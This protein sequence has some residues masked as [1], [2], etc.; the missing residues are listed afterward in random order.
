MSEKKF[1]F[2]SPGVF[3][4]EIDNSQLPR[5]PG[6]IGPMI[7]GRTRK[8]PGMRPVTVESYS[9]FVTVFG[10]PVAGAQGE[11]V[12]RDGNLTAPTYAA[13]AAQAWLK[14]NPTVTMVRL[15]GEQHPDAADGTDGAAGWK[16]G[17]LSADDN[18]GG[19][20]GL[21]LFPSGS[22]AIDANNG[23][24]TGSLVAVIYN[25]TGV[26]GNR[27]RVSGYNTAA[28]TDV[29]V[30]AS[31][32]L[33]ESA[34][35]G[36]V[37]LVMGDDSI[38]EFNFDRN[39]DKFIR[40]V[41]NTNPTLLNSDIN[42]T[43]ENYFLGESF[44]HVVGGDFNQMY[45]QLGGEQVEPN[46]STEKYLAALMPLQS[47]GGGQ[48]EQSNRLYASQKAS[49][50]WF[51]SQ[52][53]SGN[54]A[55]YKPE[56]MQKLFRIEA[57][58]G[59]SQTQ[60]EVKISVVDI[61][62]S[63]NTSD[64]Y[65]TFTILLRRLG[66][67]DARPETLER[68]SGCNLNPSSPN[69][70]AAK[71]GDRYSKYDSSEKRMKA[72]GNHSNKSNIVRVVMD[73][74]VDAGSADAAYLPFGFWGAP[75]YRNVNLVAAATDFVS[76][77]ETML[78]GSG[79]GAFGTKGSSAALDARILDGVL[80]HAPEFRFPEVPLVTDSSWVGAAPKKSYFG[81]YLGKSHT[82]ASLNPSVIDM[83]CGLAQG[84]NDPTVAYGIEE[85]G[86]T[87]D[88]NLTTSTVVTPYVFTLDDVKPVTDKPTSAE[89]VRGARLAGDSFTAGKDFPTAK[90]R[91]GASV[92]PLT[93]DE[94]WKNVLNA[95]F[96]KFTTCLHGGTDGLDI[97]ER[98]PFRNS[99]LGT[100]TTD[101][102]KHTLVRAIDVVRDPEAA[103]YNLLVAPGVTDTATTQK[104][105]DV[106]EN[107]G[108]AMAIIDLSS[109]SLIPAA[110]A[111]TS[112]EVRSANSIE[113]TVDA[114]RD[115]GLNTSY[116]ACYYPWIKI[117][118]TFTSQ[119]LW[120][121]PSI[122]ALGAYSHT[123]RV[124]APWFA[125]AGFS[126]GGLSEGAAGIPV[127]DTSRRLTS[128][129]RDALYE[130]NIN[131]IAQ[132]PAEGIVIFGQKTLQITPSALDRVNVRRL[133]IYLKK[134]IS[135]IASRMLFDQNTQSTWNRFIGQAEPILRSVKSRYGLEDF[136]LILDEST[137][138]PDLQDR[139]I[140][141]AKILLK[142]T[143]S[144]EF[145]AIDFAITNTGASFE[146]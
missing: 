31:C 113:T 120:A 47:T 1:K 116:G 46:V 103:Q 5:E 102:A 90:V 97:L 139:N 68:F 52:D 10:E 131:P 118:D 111:K 100:E 74:D 129:D 56:D 115:R 28:G 23:Q 85:A 44:E 11:D 34:T 73:S 70:I 19:A 71:I 43:V 14:N 99:A 67:T 48:E 142:P 61:K 86:A 32:T 50:G 81:T 136:K 25:K 45:S 104:M 3:V 130:A 124:K 39:S 92:N 117:Q 94:S 137:T 106:C 119:N 128:E 105:V 132:F 49:T 2:V 144:V 16:V 26:A 123:D 12:W 21:F 7:I 29:A 57:L 89:Y 96:T 77:A 22:A 4:N 72:Y 134:E 95:G 9:E 35:A 40:K 59:G 62:A 33:V 112:F 58:D 27:A 107:R 101:Y 13:Y 17:N 110:E 6:T 146:D 66:D 122:A 79:V 135:F 126:R 114:L 30:T 141:Y 84:V 63:T 15:L 53:I 76:S 80:A 133:M 143:R 125:P 82:D 108:D 109:G 18:T 78:D 60:R 145:F 83:L 65:G 64:P 69:Y 55:G 140:M 87:S 75:K 20:Q 93:Q 41:L 91:G 54:I 36:H 42:N 88:P 8:G 38:K 138:T 121:P 37:K 98:E 51:I 127:L 24:L